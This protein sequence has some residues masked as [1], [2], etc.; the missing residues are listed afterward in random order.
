MPAV[1]RES[2]GWS[3]RPAAEATEELANEL[4]VSVL[5]AVDGVRPSA[6][7]LAA[8]DGPRTRA[9]VYDGPGD[10]DD[11]SLVIDAVERPVDP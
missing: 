5:Y 4:P 8:P 10:N 6:Y 11:E 7:W 9:R 1:L 2:A 3:K